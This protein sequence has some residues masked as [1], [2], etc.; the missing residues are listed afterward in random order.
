MSQLSG[1]NLNLLLVSLLIPILVS[2]QLQNKDSDAYKHK[3]KFVLTVDKTHF[4]LD[5]C[6]IL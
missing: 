5:M 3:L 2:K 1:P 4:G 6:Q